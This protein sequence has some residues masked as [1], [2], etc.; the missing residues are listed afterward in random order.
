MIFVSNVISSFIKIL[1]DAAYYLN[2]PH[3]GKIMLHAPILVHL[4]I[5]RHLLT[6]VFT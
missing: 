6:I 5:T 3:A 1:N 4:L 2:V